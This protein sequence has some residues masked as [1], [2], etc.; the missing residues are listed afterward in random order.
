MSLSQFTVYSSSDAGNGS[1]QPGFIQGVVGDVL[2]VLDKCLVNGYTGK[3]AAG[4][5]KPVVNSSNSGCY[6]QGAG[7]L[8]TLHINDN[9]PGTGTGKECRLT[10]WESLTAVGGVGVGTGQFPL[11][12]QSLTTGFVVGRKSAT[13]DTTNRQ[14]ILFADSSTFYMFILTADSSTV[15]MGFGF[16]DVYSLKGSTDTYRC[17]VYG[18]QTENSALA[19]NSDW[20][21]TCV[22]AT[23]LANIF[24]SWFA[25]SFGGAPGG[26]S[27]QA[28][29]IGDMSLLSAVSASSANPAVGTLATPNGPDNSYY[30]SPLRIAEIAG[31]SGGGHIRGRMRGIFIIGHPIANF[32]DGQ[33]FS[34]SND[35]AGKT[36]IVVKKGFQQGMWAIE[37]SATVETN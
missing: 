19:D 33:T 35:F 7:A 22:T 23:T 36:F 6:K 10:G 14:W 8:F 25:R 24:G 3:A 31:A 32:S 16:G 30:I 34:G 37:T 18:R 13:A 4:W 20:D 26:I 29:R 17:L 28:G 27:T 15:Y 21:A 1:D 12:L 5:T 2:R 9:G 11:P